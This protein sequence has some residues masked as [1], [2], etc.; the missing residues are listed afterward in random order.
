MK[1]LIFLITFLFCSLC[2]S[3]E[4]KFKLLNDVNVQKDLFEPVVN[5][6]KNEIITLNKNYT[7]SFFYSKNNTVMIHGIYNKLELKFDINDLELLQDGIE[8]NNNFKDTIWIMP[9]YYEMLEK[10]NLSIL[11]KNEKYWNPN[12]KY[13]DFENSSFEWNY[14]FSPL[15]LKIGNYYLYGNNNLQNNPLSLLFIPIKEDLNSLEVIIYEKYSYFSQEEWKKI[16]D[17]SE[18]TVLIFKFD[19]DFLYIYSNSIN[20]ENLLYELARADQNTLD[21]ITSFVETGYYDSLKI[22]WPKHSD[23]SKETTKS[24]VSKTSLPLST[25]VTV[26]K[27]MSV[28]ENLKLRSGEATTTSVLTVIST[29]TKVK[30]LE[31]G[32]AETIDGIDSNWVKVEIQSGAKDRNGKKIKPGTIGWCYGGYLK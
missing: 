20:D 3:Q 25:N 28:T 24:Y 27:T 26:N 13:I 6:K 11:L 1:K 29:G 2:F 12:S 9:Y 17:L 4:L 18:N 15:Y 5:V 30:I 10:N 32:K 14:L 31:L 21:Q 16:Y 8:I 7:N 19:N 22:K 23:N